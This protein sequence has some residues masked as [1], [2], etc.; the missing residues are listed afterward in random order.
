MAGRRSK[1]TPDVVAR[2]VQAIELGS[3]YDMAAN[4]GG[5]TFET[6]NQWRESKAGFSEQLK[7]A[8]GRAV[9]KWLA[10]IEQARISGRGVLNEDDE[11]K[12]VVADGDD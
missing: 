11:S 3:T 5:I 2:I 4:Y 7:D 8:E 1:Y 10:K 12:S 6:L 9:V